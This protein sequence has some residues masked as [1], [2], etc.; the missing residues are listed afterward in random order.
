MIVDHSGVFNTCLIGST[1][2]NLIF[3]TI[4]PTADV[5]SQSGHANSAQ[6]IFLDRLLAWM[7]RDSSIIYK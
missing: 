7:E 5:F 1:I 2:R 6:T 3:T 4:P